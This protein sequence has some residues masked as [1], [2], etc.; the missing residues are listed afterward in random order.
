MNDLVELEELL[1]PMD[2]SVN[3][4]TKTIDISEH[5][6]FIST[7]ERIVRLF[8]LLKKLQERGE[9]IIE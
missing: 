3:S 9:K 1:Y 5:Y 4:K 7:D 6:N 8:Y 2:I